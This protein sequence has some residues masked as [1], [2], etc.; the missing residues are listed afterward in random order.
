MPSAPSTTRCT[1]NLFF[2][3]GSVD[4]ERGK[5][6]KG[7]KGEGK[8]KQK[9]GKSA[10][11]EKE[12]G[13]GK[14]ASSWKKSKSEAEKAAAAAR[15]EVCP[16]DERRLLVERLA[17]KGGSLMFLERCLLLL[18]HRALACRALG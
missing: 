10:S 15:A 4:S 7:S 17:L 6:R 2:S 5:K 3:D 1:W 11:K 8:R 14:G 13:K 18:E 12:K 9:K 16:R